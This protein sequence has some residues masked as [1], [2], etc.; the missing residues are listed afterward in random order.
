MDSGIHSSLHLNCH[1]K[2]VYGKLNLKIEYPP[3]HERLAWDYRETNTQLLNRTIE[4]LKL[5]EIT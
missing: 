3:L 2:I 4:N 5:G 1:Q